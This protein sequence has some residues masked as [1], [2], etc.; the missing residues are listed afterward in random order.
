M[1]IFDALSDLH[2]AIELLSPPPQDGEGLGE[3][4]GRSPAGHP[5][6]EVAARVW[7]C[8]A[9]GGLGPLVKL[10]WLIEGDGSKEPACAYCSETQRLV[11]WK[12]APA[13]HA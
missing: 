2:A 4:V 6:R 7:K 11:M 10:C 3:A 9:C 5:A 8:E 13:G 12:P 1:T